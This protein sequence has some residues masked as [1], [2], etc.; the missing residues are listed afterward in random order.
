MTL[1]AL[2]LSSV[3]CVSP[4]Q[5]ST[6]AGE[7][8]AILDLQTSLHY[9]LDGAGALALQLMKDP[10]SLAD[11]LARLLE[12]YEVDAE[13]ARRDLLA[14]VEVLVDRRLVDVLT[15]GTPETDRRGD[16]PR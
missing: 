14:L 13:T 6:R 8:A 7:R 16:E 3:V 2:H 1:A 10:I 4:T 11:V 12:E 15:E 9:G 5:V